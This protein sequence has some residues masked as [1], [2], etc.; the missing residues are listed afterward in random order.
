MTPM[1]ET[2]SFQSKKMMFTLER[3]LRST[4]S[5]YSIRFRLQTMRSDDWIC[6]SLFA[7][8]VSFSVAVARAVWIPL[9]WAERIRKMITIRM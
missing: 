4:Y 5:T 6:F 3:V 8:V 1:T 2:I 9:C 7:F